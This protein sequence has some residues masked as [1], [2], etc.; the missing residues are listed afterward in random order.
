MLSFDF[1]K[2]SI[3]LQFY[4]LFS[5]DTFF[6]FVSDFPAAPDDTFSVKRTLLFFHFQIGVKNLNNFVTVA[7]FILTY[8]ADFSQRHQLMKLAIF[9][10]DLH[11][12][13]HILLWFFFVYSLGDLCF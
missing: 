11:R 12:S 6:D 1:G 9:G 8:C 7:Q 4:E 2:K 5:I 13:P 3:L 10:V